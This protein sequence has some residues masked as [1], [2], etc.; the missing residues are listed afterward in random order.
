MMKYEI[1]SLCVWGDRCR[2][3]EYW[4]SLLRALAE[5]PGETIQ[6]Q[7]VSFLFSCGITEKQLE[8]IRDIFLERM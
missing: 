8:K 5:Y 4:Q 3:N 2:E 7:I 1:T 6:N